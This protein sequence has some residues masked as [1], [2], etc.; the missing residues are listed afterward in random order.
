MPRGL[1]D[2]RRARPGG[3]NGVRRAAPSAAPYVYPMG[4]H[5]FTAPRSGQWTFVGWGPGGTGG[6]AP[7]NGASGALVII[8]RFLAAGQ[9]ASL[10]AGTPN[11]SD[12]TITLPGGVVATAG[13]AS[14]ITAGAATG[15]DIN[16]PGTAG[17]NAGGSLPGAAAPSYGNFLGGA[18]GAYDF[19][20]GLG[21]G[22]G[23]GEM[24]AITI[25]GGPGLI[26]VV[27]GAL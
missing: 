11:S 8:T 16:L 1:T 23:R 14:G 5:T 12:T 26:L 18:A 13:R 9:T 25:A 21:H 22:S 19:S 10:V 24:G 17:S 7:Q 15:G 6:S 4:S 2:T 3:V 27:E 20:G